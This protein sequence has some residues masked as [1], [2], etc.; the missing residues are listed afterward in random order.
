M[1]LALQKY[2]KPFTESASH[3]KECWAEEQS[4]VNSLQLMG[5]TEGGVMEKMADAGRFTGFPTNAYAFTS[6]F[7]VNNLT[8]KIQF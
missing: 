8:M 3:L 4:S 6:P 7:F 2:L 5:K 1:Y